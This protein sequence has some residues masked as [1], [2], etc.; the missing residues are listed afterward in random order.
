MRQ[1][2]RRF[3]AALLLTSSGCSPAL[4]APTPVRMAEIPES[5]LQ[6][7]VKARP[8][9]KFDHAWTFESDGRDAY[10]IQGADREGETR[11]VIIS[12]SGE[13]LEED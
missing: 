10:K 8:D 9:V 11:T 12:R 5:V 4:D 1:P 3:I 2:V 6:V 13:V 7:A